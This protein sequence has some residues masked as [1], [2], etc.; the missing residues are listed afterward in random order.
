MCGFA[1]DSSGKTE[2]AARFVQ[3]SLVW[4]V[5]LV[6][7]FASFVQQAEGSSETLVSSCLGGSAQSHF[8]ALVVNGT[9]CGERN[10][11]LTTDFRSATIAAAHAARNRRDTTLDYSVLP[12]LVAFDGGATGTAPLAPGD[13][14]IVRFGTEGIFNAV[15]NAVSLHFK[16]IASIRESVKVVERYVTHFCKH[17]REPSA[18]L[19]M[20]LLQKCCAILYFENQSV[21]L[22]QHFSTRLRMSTALLCFWQTTRSCSRSSSI[23]SSTKEMDQSTKLTFGTRNSHGK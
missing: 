9:R 4:I 12:N 8:A 19:H 10:Q 15:S 16:S 2:H 22:V 21:F 3:S 6:N 5:V 17:Q 13:G 11:L 1:F 7:A 23:K 14:F 18:R 20:G